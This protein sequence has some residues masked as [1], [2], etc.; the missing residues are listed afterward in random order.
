[1][2]LA[3]WQGARVE[4]AASESARPAGSAA[5]PLPDP[6]GWI[7]VALPGSPAEFAE[8]DAVAYRTTFLDPRSGQRQDGEAD[9][10]GEDR[11]LVELR[12]LYARARVWLNGEY[13][14]SHDTHFAPARFT[15]EPRAAN[16]LVVLCRRPAGRFGGALDTALVAPEES[17]PAIRWG[18]SVDPIPATRIVDLSLRS[19]ETV[20]ES[21]IDA[22]VTVEAGTD[23]DD[24][25]ALSLA[26]EGFEGGSAMTRVG[27]S[28]AAG[29]RVTVAGRLPVRDPPRWWPR[30]FGDQHR[31]TVTASL[32]ASQRT[33]TTGFV[34]HEYG[35]DGLLVNDTRVPARGIE[36]L[37]PSP[38]SDPTAVV[39]DA[40]AANATVVRPH[41]H[42]PPPE[43]YEACDEA[44]LLVWQ[45]LPYCAGAFD[46]ER[47]RTIARRLGERYGHRPSLAAFG[48]FDAPEQFFAGS[49]AD[50]EPAGDAALSVRGLLSRSNAPGSDA[51]TAA[52]S[53]T[54]RARASDPGKGGDWQVR[55]TLGDLTHGA[56]AAAVIGALPDERPVLPAPGLPGTAA[57]YPAWADSPTGSGSP[58]EASSSPGS[59]SS[60]VSET[61][62]EGSMEPISWVLDGRGHLADVPVLTRCEI[63]Q[64]GEGASAGRA[65]RTWDTLATVV[66]ALRRTDLDLLTAFGLE[67]VGFPDSEASSP[68]L[69]GSS[70]ED[71]LA[72]AFEPVQAFLSGR[73]A[74]SVGVTVVNDTPER[75]AGH[76]DWTAGTETGTI[77]VEIEALSR[78]S[79]GTITVPDAAGTVELSLDLGE[80]SVINR[81]D[82]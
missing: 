20:A 47:G 48:M 30:D 1:M 70:V 18:A 59:K 15:V 73:G 76:L 8:A 67:G 14:G 17:V 7:D 9:A 46:V 35:E 16:E 42:V 50:T 23:L 54:A 26:P 78:G 58:P 6:E 66:E 43:F 52:E 79:V 2:E 10:T 53:E 33:A 40:L 32:G 45:P 4:P 41:A 38:G 24:R 36:T 82:R 68:E 25:I 63:P 81:Y 55:R 80:R 11:A 72:D 71:A 12:G 60:V 57:R 28:A 61:T 74:G 51:E 27:V 5:P 49:D 13:L 19:H 69:S 62:D 44:G 37:P 75:V 77:E 56:A 31:Y 22:T 64:P 65:D 34:S 39:E 3:D 29:E 21:W